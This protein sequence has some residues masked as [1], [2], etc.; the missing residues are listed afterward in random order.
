[1]RFGL[2]L[3]DRIRNAPELNI[4]SELYYIGFLDLTSC[5]ILGMGL[6]PIPLLAILEYCLIK[7]IEGEQ[8]EDFV[9]FVQRLDSRYLEW[10]AARAKSK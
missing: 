3:P 8:Q 5:R 1:M 9:W 6:G 4:G 7:G 2:P 10:G